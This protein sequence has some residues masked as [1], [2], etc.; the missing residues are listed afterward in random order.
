[1]SVRLPKG[2][3]WVREPVHACDRLQSLPIR[4]PVCGADISPHRSSPSG[5]PL[6]PRHMWHTGRAWLQRL[7]L[8]QANIP[9]LTS[10]PFWCRPA[11]PH[12]AWR[13]SD[14][15]LPVRH[16]RAPHRHQVRARG[17]AARGTACTA[18]GCTT[19][20]RSLRQRDRILLTAGGH[21]TAACT[22]VTSVMVFQP[23]LAAA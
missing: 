14:V 10:L 13:C 1:M 8:S 12:R 6:H 9:A 23:T 3:A 19:R 2:R 18:R 16:A 15:R 21:S 20:A 22:G 17:H 5:S 4:V 7:H 11:D